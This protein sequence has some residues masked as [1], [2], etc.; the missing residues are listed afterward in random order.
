[1]SKKREREVG[2]VRCSKKPYLKLL[3]DIPVRVVHTWNGLKHMM[4]S[5]SATGTIHAQAD[6][7]LL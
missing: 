7:S 4:V 1:M 5:F 3:L 2:E 6:D